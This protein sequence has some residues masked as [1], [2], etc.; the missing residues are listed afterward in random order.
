MTEA[1]NR[2]LLKSLQQHLS[3]L[4]PDSQREVE[5]YA[6]SLRELVDEVGGAMRLAIML[7]HFENKVRLED[8][9]LRRPPPPH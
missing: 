6:T 2:A 3:E 8:L 7:V 1:D 4:P 9:G 5:K